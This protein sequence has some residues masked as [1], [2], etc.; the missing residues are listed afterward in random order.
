MTSPHTEQTRAGTRYRVQI[1]TYQP[2]LEGS[3]M[4]SAS[5][6]I[7]VPVKLQR[8]LELLGPALATDLAGDPAPWAVDGTLGMAGHAAALLTRHPNMRLLGV[9]RDPQALELAA[10]RLTFAE[11]RVVLRH[12]VFDEIPD[13]LHELGS[14]AVRAVL[15]DLGVSSL[16]LDSAQRGFAYA[17]DTPLDM[18]MDQTAGRSARDVVNGYT[19]KELARVFREYGEERFAGRIANAIA[20]A[21]AVSP[22]ES[23]SVLAELIRDSVPAPARRTGGHPAKRVFQALRI[24]V[25]D[26]LGALGRLLDELPGLLAVGGRAVV[27]SY[28]SLEDRLVKRAFARVTR[29]DLPLDLPVLP[30]PAAYRLLTRGAE[31]ASESEVAANPRAASVRL[32]AIVRETA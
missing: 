16:Q 2:Q 1:P 10:S 20:S 27:L 18:R 30:P 22:I 5:D 28:Q 14:P 9:D 17:R 3:A 7:H 29:S 31:L 12:A 21:R 8:T 11:D 15:L 25:N 6:D 26:E 24:E 23:T 32:R 13:L 19:A 4:D